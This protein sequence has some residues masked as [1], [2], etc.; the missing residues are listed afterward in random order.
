VTFFPGRDVAV[1]ATYAHPPTDGE[2]RAILDRL[3]QMVDDTPAGGQI[4]ATV[5][6]LTVEP[7]RDALLAAA[8]RGVTVQVLQN[9]RGAA[10][11]VGASLSRPVPI[12]LGEGHRFAGRAFDPTGEW[13]AYGAIATGPESDLHTK[14]VLFSATRDPVGR[15]REHVCWWSSANLAERS[16]TEKANNAVAVY[17]D[18]TLYAGFLERLWD[19]LWSQTHFP[20]NDFYNGSRGRGAFLGGPQSRTKVFCSPE[21]DTDLWLGRLGSVV[22]GSGAAI[23]VV[24]ARFTDDR[25]AVAARLAELSRQGATVR[26]LVGSN[27]ALLGATVHATLREAGI[28]VRRAN[29]HDK[30]VL[31]H[32]RHASSRRPRKVVLSGSHNLN[33]DA[34][35]RNDEILVKTF[36][37]GL[38][39]DLRARHVDPLW[40][41]AVP[42]TG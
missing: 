20:R 17:G 9:G 5:F 11:A 10:D 15:L 27:P 6:R 14:L 19:L 41:A 13:T 36:H 30:L 38:Y 1:E 12:G 29:L 24:H 28:P 2:D 37:D 8:R 25:A 32:A 33:H 40:A 3:V 23:D 16:G 31:L 18:A 35:Y 4:R 26:V 7:V 21:Q 34:N 42:L 39:D 22:A